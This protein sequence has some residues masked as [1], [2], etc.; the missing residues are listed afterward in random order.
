MGAKFREEMVPQLSEGMK[1][2]EMVSKLHEV[3]VHQ[4]S[5]EL[6]LN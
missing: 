6:E 1:R 3:M 5:E 2:E 4:L